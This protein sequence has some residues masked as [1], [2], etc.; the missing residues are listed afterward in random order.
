PRRNPEILEADLAPMMLELSQWGVRDIH[1]LT[2]ITP[3]P[4]GA[5][6]QALQLLNELGAVSDTT[7]TEKGRQMLRLPTHPR[8]AHMLLEAENTGGR[9][10]ALALASDIAAVLEERDPLP[11]NS[12]ADLSLRIESLRRWRRGERG[13]PEKTSLERIERL[14]QS[15]R[16]LLKIPANNQ[17]VS[18]TEVGKWVMQA[19]P[20]RIARQ[21]EP[22]SERYKMT[23][24]RTARLP[25]HDPLQR[26]PW[27]AVA[28]LD[29]GANEGKIFLAAP[30]DPDDV[31]PLAKENETVSWDDARE[32]ITGSLEMRV[33]NL[34]LSSRPLKQIPE[35][36]LAK[37]LCRVIREKGLSF[38]GWS[39][40]QINWQTRVL[41]LRK[42][43]PE[44]NWPDVTEEN[45]LDTLE[46]WLGPF[47]HNLYKRADLQKL[48]LNSILSSI[49]PWELS[50]ELHV[51]APARLQ[52]PSGSLVRLTYFS[53]GRPPVMEVRLQEMF[54]LLETPAVNQGR[55]KVILHLLSPGYK[56]V[57]VTQDLKS[58][59][60]TTYQEVRRE[61]R[62]RYPKH[63]WPEDPW[64]AQPIRGARKKDNRSPGK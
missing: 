27:L 6:S 35:E 1:S 51:L 10:S 22:H 60:T 19:Y 36:I 52:V 8:L 37:E 21:T 42:W 14:A 3:P 33:G 5:V 46:H 13:G 43:R 7:I 23:N 64:T 41:S 29:A 48:D 25:A 16:Q 9:D 39:E 40:D 28:Q 2:W 15:W 4:P 47:L 24:G 55:N 57:Q 44:E 30:L 38:V 31:L 58:F 61:L 53:D 11:K 12:G 62:V 59:W 17:A 18:D 50:Q 63:S 54:G 34:V 32:M 20:E 45:L 26:E 56:P 49:L